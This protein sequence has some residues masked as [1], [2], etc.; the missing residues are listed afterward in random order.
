MA[1]LCGDQD[2]GAFVRGAGLLHLLEGVAVHQD[3]PVEHPQLEPEQD[4]RPTVPMA[5]TV[6]AMVARSTLLH[7]LRCRQT[8]AERH[9]KGAS[10]ALGRFFPPLFLPPRLAALRAIFLCGRPHLRLSLENTR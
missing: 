3:L 8:Q 4:R 5:E 9:S 10:K 2:G 1:E 7:L 6:C